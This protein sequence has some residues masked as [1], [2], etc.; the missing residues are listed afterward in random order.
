MNRNVYVVTHGTVDVITF[1]KDSTLRK[2]NLNHGPSSSAPTEH[3]VRAQRWAGANVPGERVT[4]TIRGNQYRW[5]NSCPIDATL[6]AVGN[7]AA[8]SSAFR[9]MLEVHAPKVAAYV[10]ALWSPMGVAN[11]DAQLRQLRH[12]AA[13]DMITRQLHADERRI[14]SHRVVHLSGT[15]RKIISTYGGISDWINLALPNRPFT[16]A[17]HYEDFT[18]NSTILDTI[19]QRANL[20]STEIRHTNNQIA[21][22]HSLV[23]ENGHLQRSNELL[24]SWNNQ[25]AKIRSNN[26][27][28]KYVST[29]KV[30]YWR[31]L[32]L[33]GRMPIDNKCNRAKP[34]FRRNPEEHNRLT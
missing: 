19:R 25:F 31:L 28:T 24:N 26:S 4:F 13:F 27:N 30:A 17:T 3:Q 14:E 10:R 7:A 5:T 29:V 8:R 2:V 33:Q 21:Y 11:N 32:G 20:D 1:A 16:C 6:L 18:C 12:V 34:M 23:A 22:K 9:T 15:H